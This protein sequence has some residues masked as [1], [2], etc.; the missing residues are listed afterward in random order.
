MT[1]AVPS[2]LGVRVKRV[3]LF[4][5]VV[6][7]VAGSFIALELASLAGVDAAVAYPGVF[8]NIAVARS[9]S[10]STLC[11]VTSTSTAAATSPQLLAGAWTLG[12]RLGREAEA[13]QS[14]TVKAETLVQARAGVEQVAALLQ[15]PAPA[16]FE[17]TDLAT[18]NIA[19]VNTIEADTQGT[20]KALAT[21]YSPAS[22][23]LYK[24][25]AVWGQ[26]AIGRSFLPGERPPLASELRLYAQ[27]AGLPE[28][29]WKAM[30]EPSQAGASGEALFAESQ[31]LTAGV[32]TY[33]LQLSP[34]APAR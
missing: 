28:P 20:A 29:L 23:R 4:V 18:A 10:R 32:T 8:G 9:A 33:L 2:S 3:A 5:A 30:T 25:G 16:R 7:A 15:I 26:V 21:V 13:R 31:A 24:L 19:F 14:P 1:A 27:Q 17:P 6:W 34:P 12:L 11:D 22:C